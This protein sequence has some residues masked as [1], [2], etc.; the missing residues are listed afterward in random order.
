MAF[1]ASLELVALG[2]GGFDG[3]ILLG[4]V[5]GAHELEDGGSSDKSADSTNLLNQTGHGVGILV[6][7]GLDTSL[8]LG[9]NQSP[10]GNGEVAE[11]LLVSV[12]LEIFVGRAKSMALTAEAA[13]VHALGVHEVTEGHEA[14]CT[15][16]EGHN[17]SGEAVKV[18][19]VMV[20]LALVLLD[21]LK[22]LNG[23]RW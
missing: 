23:V 15:D 9:D 22:E 10:D 6:L 18:S 21:V 2:L 16:S 20:D 12:R 5:H 1:L 19:L 17:E 14:E 11:G 4:V 13:L 7:G 3:D 8:G